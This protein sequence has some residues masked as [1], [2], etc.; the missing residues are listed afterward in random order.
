MNLMNDEQKIDRLMAAVIQEQDAENAIRAITRLG[1]YVTR[2][3]SYGGFLGRR[4]STL[5]IGLNE[6]QIPL[7]TKALARSCRRRVEYLATPLEGSPLPFPSPAPITVGGATIFTFEIERYEQFPSSER[8][9]TNQPGSNHDSEH[10]HIGLL[11]AI[12]QDRDRE[13]IS[14]ALLNCGFRVTQIASSG[15]FLRRGSTTMMIGVEDDRLEEVLAIFQNHCSST[16]GTG[17]QVIVFVVQV[18][19]FEQI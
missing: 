11:L 16:P 19:R 1:I 6:S 17:K 15:G 4:N 13:T 5:L 12:V 3:S 2:L 7:A 14:Q 18:E 8:M 9:I 10:T